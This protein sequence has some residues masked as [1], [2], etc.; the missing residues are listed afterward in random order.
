VW[1]N[2]AYRR[3]CT[4]RD[5]GCMSDHASAGKRAKEL[6]QLIR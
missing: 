6:N 1:R 2:G 5:N 3:V 4:L